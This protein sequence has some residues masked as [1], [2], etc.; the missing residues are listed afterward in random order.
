MVK[1]SVNVMLFTG[2][3][4]EEFFVGLPVTGVDAAVADHLIMLFRDVLDETLD[5]FEGRDRFFHIFVVLVAVVVESDRV[6]IVFI[7]S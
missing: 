6:T 4:A 1:T 7:D 3:G 2:D 5:K